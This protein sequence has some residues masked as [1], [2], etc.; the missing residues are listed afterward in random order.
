MKDG[1]EAR[2]AEL[3]DL[4]R[5]YQNEYYVQ[6]RPS[7]SDAEYD[8]LFDRVMD[9]SKVLAATGMVQE[10]LMKL[11]DGLKYEISRCPKDHPWPVNKRIDD[12]LAAMK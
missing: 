7:V 11:Y 6:S 4:L 5:R 8:R 10:K 2:I 9:N 12:Y 3:S 1:P